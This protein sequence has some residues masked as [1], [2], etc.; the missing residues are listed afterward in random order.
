MIDNKLKEHIIQQKPSIDI[1]KNFMFFSNAKVAQRSIMWNLLSNRIIIAVRGYKNYKVF[2]D[3]HSNDDIDQIFKFSIVRNPWDRTVSAFH[4]L[5]QTWQKKPSKRNLTIIDKNE[6]FKDFVKNKLAVEGVEINPH[7]RHQYP[8]VE[9]NKKIFVDFI[10]RFENLQ[11][12]WNKIAAI[13]DAPE[14]LPHNNSSKHNHYRT[15]YDDETVK[16]VQKIYSRDIKLLKY[17]F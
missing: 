9:Y 7:F 14:K 5:K 10:G 2:M 4:Y 15:Y 3:S 8:N 11:N 12:D 6:T 13:I 1:Y 17:K 16:T